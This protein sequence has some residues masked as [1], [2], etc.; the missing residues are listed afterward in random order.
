M[1]GEN[2]PDQILQEIYVVNFLT[3]LL[4]FTS[5]KISKVFDTLINFYLVDWVRLKVEKG[6]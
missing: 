2:L 5:A 4:C 3:W 1:E 6:H